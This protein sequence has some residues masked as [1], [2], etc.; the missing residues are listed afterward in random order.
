MIEILFLHPETWKLGAVNCMVS[1]VI[2]WVSPYFVPTNR[3]GGASHLNDPDRQSPWSLI[4]VDKVNRHW[5]FSLISLLGSLLHM[6]HA[7]TC[8]FISILLQDLILVM[9]KRYRFFFTPNMAC[10]FWSRFW[11]I[12]IVPTNS[13][14]D[15]QKANTFIWIDLLI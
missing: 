12:Y 10:V 14:F 5:I 7:G 2:F 13:V 4:Q 6:T 3:T 8:S 15:F 1:C 9:K 11:S